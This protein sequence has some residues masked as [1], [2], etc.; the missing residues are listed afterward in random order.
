[1][2][3]G[4]MLLQMTKQDE[5]SG[6]SRQD[7]LVQQHKNDY[8]FD[9]QYSL[10]TTKTPFIHTWSFFHVKSATMA[11]ISQDSPAL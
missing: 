4:N 3:I 9:K 10:T 8:L 5:W 11:I 1:M 2:L 7:F 6:C